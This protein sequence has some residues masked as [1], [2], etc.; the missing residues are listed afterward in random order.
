MNTCIFIIRKLTEVKNFQY[1][2]NVPNFKQIFSI[3]RLER[4]NF[5]TIKP[6]RVLR[7]P[8]GFQIGKIPFWEP[9]GVFKT[10]RGLE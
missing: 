5:R 7:T 3:Q 4:L 9:G 1:P 10:R 2:F 6:P 8:R